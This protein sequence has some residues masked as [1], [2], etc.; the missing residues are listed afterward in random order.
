MTRLR[1]LAARLR[2]RRARPAPCPRC[3]TARAVVDAARLVERAWTNPGP[4][5]VVH[6][7]IQN[8][9]RQAWPFLAAS[10]DSLTNALNDHRKN[11]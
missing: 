5:P 1:S 2:P 9:T 3:C 8:Q 4:R 7:R 11:T 10:I 6:R